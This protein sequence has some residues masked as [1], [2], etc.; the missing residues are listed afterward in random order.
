MRIEDIEPYY[1]V[2]LE[3]ILKMFSDLKDDQIIVCLGTEKTILISG[4]PNIKYELMKYKKQDDPK[5]N[6]KIKNKIYILTNIYHQVFRKDHN[7]LIK[8]GY[9]YTPRTENYNSFFASALF[10]Q[11]NA[12]QFQ[13][14]TK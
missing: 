1:F 4:K 8:L 2:D 3:K 7:Y 6:I 14:R 12:K 11:G 9:F 13:R 10:Y 5:A